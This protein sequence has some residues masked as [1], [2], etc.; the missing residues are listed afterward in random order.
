M[1]LP[2]F[3]PGSSTWQADVLN[4]ARLQPLVHAFCWFTTLWR[5]LFNLPEKAY[6]LLIHYVFES[7]LDELLGFLTRVGFFADVGFVAGV[8]VA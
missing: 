1:R 2:G 5:Y 6:A 8:G 3:E 7:F 4:Q